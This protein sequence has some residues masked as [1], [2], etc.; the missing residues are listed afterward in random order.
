MR[1]TLQP[2]SKSALRLPLFS[3]MATLTAQAVASPQSVYEQRR[4]DSTLGQVVY[5]LWVDRFVPPLHP[6]SLANKYPAPKAFHKWSEVAM[7]GHYDKKAQYWSH[8]LEFWGGTL[9]R[10]P[11]MLPYIKGLGVDTIYL[12]PV[13][14]AY[15]SHKYDT[16]DYYRVAPE[17]GTNKD[18]VNLFNSSHRNGLKVVLDGVFNHVGMRFPRFVQAK[19]GNQFRDWFSFEPKYPNGYLSF[20]GVPSLPSLNLDNPIVR[21]YL[22]NGKDSVVRHWLDQG[23]DGWRLDVA[24][25][26]GPKYLQELTRAAH[27][28]KKGS[29]V[30]GEIRGYPSDWFP[31]VDGVFNF[32]ALTL[33]KQMVAGE[34]KGQ[35]VGQMYADM[36]ADSPYENVL[37][38]WLVADNGDTIRLASMVPDFKDRS[39]VEALQFSLP[40]SPMIYYGSELGMTG[41]SDIEARSPMR[42]DLANQNNRD[43]PWVRSLS[44]LRKKK[45]SLRIGDLKLL[46]TNELLAFTRSTDRLREA[47]IVVMNP[48]DHAVTE[49]FGTRIGRAMT[50]ATYVDAFTGQMAIAIDGIMKVSMSPKSVRFF[51]VAVPT[52][53]PYDPYRRIE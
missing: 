23:A 34:I 50:Y 22:W 11:E 53:S 38:S 37:K 30:V 18:L 9:Q 19:K 31:A 40:G 15:S 29:I 24:Y 42:W 32:Y 14:D 8:E 41:T 46:R 28:E 48:T 6:E 2:D 51:S 21:Q 44:L 5:E 20:A 45:A 16:T 25:E 36:V 10:I 43:L 39:L 1:I 35:Q 49:S 52:G 33:A 7:P 13:F 4:K 47:V 17:F 26:L 3:L 12:R 27:S